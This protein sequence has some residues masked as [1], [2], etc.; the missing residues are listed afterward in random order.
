M[1][2]FAKISKR[3]LLFLYINTFPTSVAL[4]EGVDA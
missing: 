2:A 4:Q 3:R 1:A